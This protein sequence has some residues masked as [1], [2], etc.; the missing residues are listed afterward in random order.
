MPGTR[1][2]PRKSSGPAAKGTQKTLAFSNNRVTKSTT[3]PVGKPSSEPPAKKPKIAEEDVKVTEENVKLPEVAQAQVQFKTDEEEKASHITEAQIK[4]YWRDREAERKAPRVHQ[5][6]VSLEEKILRLWDMSS[7]FGPA[8]GSARQ[9]RWYRA[10]K[11]GLNPPIEVL[12]V[13]LREEEKGNAKI[14]RAHVDE[15]MS[16]KFAIGEA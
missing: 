15:L 6:D 10:H 2:A 7:Q 3:H 13:L 8:I 4:K 5:K 11:L 16:S 12:A 9:K 1:R 14:E